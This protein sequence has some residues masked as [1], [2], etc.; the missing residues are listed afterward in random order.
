MAAIRL[1]GIVKLIQEPDQVVDHLCA[2][3]L[4]IPPARFTERFEL[5]ALWVGLIAPDLWLEP[6]RVGDLYGVRGRIGNQEYPVW[7]VADCSAIPA[8]FAGLSRF[9]DLTIPRINNFRNRLDN[10]ELPG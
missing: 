1:R 6:I 7:M 8:L 3:H 9:I 4:R 10:T 5:A 2:E